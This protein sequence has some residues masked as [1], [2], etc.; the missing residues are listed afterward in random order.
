MLYRD[1]II[2]PYKESLLTNQYFIESKGPRVFFVAHLLNDGFA[3][4]RLFGLGP[5]GKAM[6]FLSSIREAGSKGRAMDGDDWNP[7]QFNL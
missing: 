7:F 4:L 6:M 1:I 5:V 2:H 3:N